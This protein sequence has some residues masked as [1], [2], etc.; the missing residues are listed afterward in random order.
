MNSFKSAEKKVFER[1]SVYS[2]L[3]ANWLKTPKRVPII[4]MQLMSSVDTGMVKLKLD[5]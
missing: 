4:R 5:W 3:T 1:M 2:P